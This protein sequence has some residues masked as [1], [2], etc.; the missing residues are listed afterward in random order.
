VFRDSC[1]KRDQEIICGVVEGFY[2]RP[3]TTE[4][5]RH[6][7]K[8]LRKLGMNTYLYAPKDDLKHRAEVKL[9]K[10]KIETQSKLLLK[11]HSV[12]NSLHCRR[13]R[14]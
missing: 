10:C 9:S 4:Q 12:A 13:D 3:W 6:L 14:Y 8:K 7:F 2:G 1:Q 5:R 11:M